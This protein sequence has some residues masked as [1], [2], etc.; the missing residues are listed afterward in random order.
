[1]TPPDLQLRLLSAPDVLQPG[2]QVVVQVRRWGIT[3]RV[4]TEVV[5][6]EDGALLVE[7]QREGPFR[8]WDHTRRFE[9]LAGG[10]TRLTEQIDYEPPTGLLGNMLTAALVERELMRAFDYR[11][12]RLPEL[13]ASEVRS[14]PRGG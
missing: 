12:T 3:R 13:L 2:S 1:V 7:E 6:L 10:G 11:A 5:S 9:A 4:V 8:L 14:A